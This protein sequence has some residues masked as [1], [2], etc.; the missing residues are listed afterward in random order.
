MRN[1]EFEKQYKIGE[2]VG[3]S[4][5]YIAGEGWAICTDGRMYLTER[6]AE[7]KGDDYY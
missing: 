4:E 3:T 6:T 2:K 7:H 5:C 1:V